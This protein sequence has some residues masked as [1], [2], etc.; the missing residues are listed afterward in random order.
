MKC[1]EE[2]TQ[3]Q[4]LGAEGSCQWVE[5][6]ATAREARSTGSSPDAKFH[7]EDPLPP[8]TFLQELSDLPGVSV[9]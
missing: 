7:C 5:Q 3:G 2:R 6:A 1:R 4:N 8:R 9:L